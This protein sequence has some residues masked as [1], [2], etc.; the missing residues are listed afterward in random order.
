[1]GIHQRRAKTARAIIDLAEVVSDILEE[2]LQNNE[3]GLTAADIT[4]RTGTTVWDQSRY[5]MILGILGYLAE[6]DIAE[7][8]QP[9]PGPGSWRL[10][11]PAGSK[12]L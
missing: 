6:L 8:S 1:M 12:P 9:G 4:S 2:A 3:G 5:Q 11:M 10:K 7:D